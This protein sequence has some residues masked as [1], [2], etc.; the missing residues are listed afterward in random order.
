MSTKVLYTVYRTIPRVTVSKVTKVVTATCSVPPRQT[1]PDKTCRIKPTVAHAAAFDGGRK[2]MEI[3]PL[4]GNMP[5]ATPPPFVNKAPQQVSSIVHIL[6][7]TSTV[8]S[9]TKSKSAFDWTTP[10]PPN[11][12][13][14]GRVFWARDLNDKPKFL[15]ERSARLEAMGVKKRSPDQATV[16]VT[17]TN[18]AV[19]PTVTSTILVSTR[20]MTLT[21]TATVYKTVKPVPVTVLKG[22]K[23][24][25]Q[26]VVTMPKSTRTST[27]YIVASATTIKM[28]THT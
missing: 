5:G 21:S 14:F 18:T 8:K 12:D 17:N 4:V 25:A 6:E 26:V 1:T 20:Y 16:T 13:R 22:E 15:A 11:M 10:I 24:A 23:T 2:S 3:D 27:K 9:A 19:W 28:I 7:R